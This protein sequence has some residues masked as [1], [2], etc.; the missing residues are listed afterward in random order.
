MTS[1]FREWL[2]SGTQDSVP[3]FVI[4][5]SHR[6]SFLITGRN[7][8]RDCAV[9]SLVL[10]NFLYST[11]AYAVDIEDFE[12]YVN[13]AAEACALVCNPPPSTP[14]TEAGRIFYD[15]P[16]SFSCPNC[17]GGWYY[18][19]GPDGRFLGYTQIREMTYYYNPSARECFLS[20]VDQYKFIYPYPTSCPAGENLEGP[21]P[22]GYCRAANYE[23]ELG[24][25]QCGIGNPCNPSNGNKYQREND[26]EGGQNGLSVTRYYN[27]LSTWGL[28]IGKGWSTLSSTRLQFLAPTYDNQPVATGTTIRL[29]RE[30][31]RGEKFTKSID[32]TWVGDAE[33]NI[34]LAEEATTY[35]LTLPQ[36]ERERYDQNGKLLSK[37]DAAGQVT[38]Y[39]HD[40]N[41]RLAS[42]TGSYGHKL[43]F[44]YNTSNH[45][46][47]ITDPDNK[48][49][50]YLYDANNNLT[51]V[52]Y[53]DNTAKLYHY[54]NTS[55]PNHLTGISFVDSAGVTTRYATYA[56]DT[57]GKAA[58]T[59]HA[60]TD[61]GSP[62]EKFTLTY[63]SATQTT[64]T[65][66]V[67]MQEVMT[68]ATNL[69]V[70]NLTSKVNQSDL[71]S[72][73]QTFDTN[74]NLTCRKDEE[75][76]VTLYSYN[77]TN[78]KT[79][80]TEGLS[81]DCTNPVTVAGVTRT[82]NYAYLSP[83]LDLP[84]AVSSPSVYSGQ[85]KTTT[86]Q[87]TDTAHPNL[88]T[89]ITQSGYTP[90]GASVSRTVTLGYNVYGQVNLINGPRTDVTDITTLE[91]NECTAGYGCGQ[92]KK[93][94]NALGHITTY[95][96][97]D[98]NGRLLQMTGPNGLRTAYSYDARGRVK[99]VT[100]TPTSGASALTQYSY[101][102]W[103]DIAQVIDPDGVRLDY[104]YDAAHDLRFIVD[105]AGNYIHYTYDLKGNRTGDYT[106]DANGVLKRSVTQ[107]YDLRNHLSQINLAGDIT[108]VV[109]DAVGN[110]ASETDPNNHSTTHQYDALNRLFKTVNALSQ[111]TTYGQDV[112]DRPKT[113][114]APNTL[115]T[116]Y[117]YDDFGN[118]LQ[119]ISPDRGTTVYTHDGAGNV[120]TAT[121]ALGQ[122]TTY[123]Y[124]ALNR[125]SVQQS[126]E[127]NTPRYNYSYDGCFQGQLCNVSRNG[128]GYL[129]LGYDM[130][131]RPSSQTDL[132]TG[133]Y[134]S[135]A[136]S[137]GGRLT[138]ITY[139]NNRKVNYQYDALG[140]VSQVSTTTAG[141]VTT[142]LASNLTYYP[143]GPVGGFTFGNDQ[144]YLANLDQAYRP[145]LHVSGPRMKF[146]DY[147][148][149]GNL[150]TLTD[151]NGQQQSFGYNELDELASASDTQTGSYGNLSYLYLDNS[152]RRRET[153][154]GVNSRYTY[155][156][157]SNRLINT[158]T[159]YWLYNAAGSAIWSSNA[160]IMSYDG[161][162]RMVSAL[163]GTATYDYNPFNQRTRKTA[164]G[165]TTSFHYG[166]QGELLYETDGTTKTAYIYLNG[167][168]LARADKGTIYYY[169]TDHLGTPQQ[170]TNSAGAT[171]WKANYEPFGW[172]V[173]TNQ[174]IQNNV[175]LAGQY[176]DSETGLLYGGA[177]YWDPRIGRSI[178]ADRMSVAEHVERWQEN[179]GAPGQ[180][181][182]EINPYVAVANNPL[183]YTDRTGNAIDTVADVGFILYDLYRIGADNLFGDIRNFG[184]N[185]AALGADAGGLLIPGATGLGLGVRAAKSIAPQI[186]KIEKQLAQHGRGSVEKSLRN[187]EARLAE[188]R[189][190]LET[191]KAQGGYTSSVGREIRAFEA[192]IKAIKQ[193]LGRA[194]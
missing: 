104:Q 192:E 157:S 26:Y 31:G 25:K 20:T 16:P 124:D 53:P 130:L 129:I 156:D 35:N 115:S 107:A 135:Y 32:G 4:S 67:N 57:T 95:D 155:G 118:L 121:N 153:R 127:V 139:P 165:V 3:R 14:C 106:Y 133:L 97:Y 45:I 15:G 98:A 110:L 114:T 8:L 2:H 74:N 88:P 54:E 64:V 91:Y 43:T 99:T 154:N 87:Y 90:A 89:V 79:S 177:R 86:I 21:T 191:Y 81:G 23:K 63:N 152:N 150:K 185:C 49:I 76:R 56:Y 62:Q 126:S 145:G 194:P 187:L 42:V 103:G 13:T 72:V 162:G 146:A 173:V 83:T 143:F 78:Q 122:I 19:P 33:T 102:P 168:L 17:G 101:T 39:N 158:S 29:W 176:F 37:T 73:Q 92:L 55:F 183:R 174:V 190:A 167:M 112:N 113:V 163:S 147:D 36:G 51:R 184:E 108:Q 144:S 65:D 60:Q 28:D 105:A 41:G 22:P 142:T 188:H 10:G 80:L 11:A 69:G 182:L 82:T 85:N 149:A 164:G 1:L 123:T 169:H 100:Q 66:P 30:D 151:S 179:L 125:V 180:P 52:D 27:S 134:S 59:Q 137:L 6:F 68:F 193:V 50:E 131:G 24:G 132:S 109:H 47:T 116:Q 40:T 120:I 119:E 94:T 136:Y 9:Y 44:A 128:V 75:N 160:Y 34:S 181:P 84:T 186:A 7:K 70:K 117:E 140:R 172:A 96:L 71:K 18:G 171:V 141:G 138:Q 178:T 58:L 166:P 61:N 189:K 111:E 38:T 161:Y 5:L 159:L 93:V 148:P 170:M 77:A 175:R 46:A 48:V 12:Y